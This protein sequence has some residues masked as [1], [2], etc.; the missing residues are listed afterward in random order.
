MS[1]ARLTAFLMLFLGCPVLSSSFFLH[2][3]FAEDMPE[4]RLENLKSIPYLTW[5]SPD[6]DVKS[7]SG[8]TVYDEERAFRGLN[9]YVSLSENI[10]RLMDMKGHILHRW[11]FEQK[12]WQMVEMAADGT[13]YAIKYDRRL[14]KL[15][16]DS[17]MIWKKRVRVHHEILIKDNGDVLILTN[18][19]RLI[20]REGETFPLLDNR[21]TVLS[22]EGRV[23][24]RVS[25]YRLFGG[26]LPEGRIAMLREELERNPESLDESNKLRGITVFNAL[27]TN[28]LDLIDR[29][30]PGFARKGNLLI[31]VRE[32]DTVAVVDME[33]R[34][35]VWRWGPGVIHKQHDARL[36]DNGLILIFDNQGLRNGSSRV[37]E[38]D[39]VRKEIVREYRG[40]ENSPFYSGNRGASQKLPNGNILVTE[41]NEGH[42]FEITPEDEIVWEFWNPVIDESKQA[43]AAIYRLRRLD[44]AAIAGLPFDAETRQSLVENH[45]LEENA[46]SLLQR[47]PQQR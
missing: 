32:L 31:S 21:I 46:P 5:S 12:K 44:A 9:L 41:S 18:H 36:L 17:H 7:K 4:D 13:I 47:V 43:R 26:E 10:A 29:D 28:S 22:P 34:A 3:A 38:V 16:W 8:V 1:F 37:L 39:P 19:K 20:E 45:Y 11:F 25:V 23:K 24:D 27:H 40:P 14:L 6:P 42:I 33:A 15:D 2:A 35:I 30:I